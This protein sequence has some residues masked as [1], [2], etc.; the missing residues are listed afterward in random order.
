M[1]QTLYKF[2][3]VPP[4]PAN[5]RQNDSTNAHVLMASNCIIYLLQMN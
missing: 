1:F 5:N 2:Y 3:D 4:L